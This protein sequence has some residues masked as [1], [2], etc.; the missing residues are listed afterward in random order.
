MADSYNYRLY[1]VIRAEAL[2]DEIC[3]NLIKRF[4]QFRLFSDIYSF[5]I[6]PAIIRIFR[7]PRPLYC[8]S[9]NPSAQFSFGG[10]V[11]FISSDR[12]RSV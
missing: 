5:L 4:V 2:L 1:F 12:F 3:V 11:I 10:V 8:F 7:D 6:F 9:Y